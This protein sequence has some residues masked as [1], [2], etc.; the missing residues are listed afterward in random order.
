MPDP[1]LDRGQGK[2]IRHRDGD[3]GIKDG[4]GG[5]GIRDSDGGSGISQFHPEVPT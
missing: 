2:G 3:R 4:D 1:D 5:G